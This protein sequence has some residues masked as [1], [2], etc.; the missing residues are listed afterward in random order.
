MGRKNLRRNK[1][2]SNFIGSKR[3]YN[4]PTQNTAYGYAENSYNP[5]LYYDGDATLLD[6]ANQSIAEQGEADLYA[7]VQLDQ[8]LAMNPQQ[9]MQTFS[10]VGNTLSTV[11]KGYDKINPPPVAPP[12]A[13]TAYGVEAGLSGGL[14][15]TAAASGGGKLMSSAGNWLKS[16]AGIGTIAAI[17]GDLL[18][19]TEWGDDQ[20][21]TTYKFGEGFSDVLSYGGRGAAYGS[22][23]G[24]AGTAVGAVLGTAYGL[25]S[26]FSNRNE[27]RTEQKK[28]EN[29]QAS[30]MKQLQEKKQGIMNKLRTV[31]GS[32]TGRSLVRTR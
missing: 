10:S 2:G 17:G 7:Q 4:A 24:P 31:S 15:G 13:T 21:P 14:N 16:G 9:D 19:R 8:T 29:E 5:Q 12:V 25:F 6:A 23:F 30:R 3:K 27:A 11:K 1:N 18:D 32:N 20:D 26:G 28:L 22:M